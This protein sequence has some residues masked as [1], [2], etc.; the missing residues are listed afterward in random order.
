MTVETDGLLESLED[1]AESLKTKDIEAIFKHY[2]TH[3][4]SMIVKA[5]RREY[6]STALSN[7]DLIDTYVFFETVVADTT[8]R[9][10]LCE[11]LA[12]VPGGSQV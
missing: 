4:M 1:I 7:M 10:I 2:G 3:S 11:C 6:T 8:Y 12:V 5:L 9:K